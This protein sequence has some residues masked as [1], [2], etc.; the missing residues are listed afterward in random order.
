MK[1]QYL[2]SSLKGDAALQF[3]H[4]PLDD[5]SYAPTWQALLN[6]Y[7]DDKLLKREYFKALVQLEPMNAA[8][9]VELTRIVNETRRLVQGMERLEE[10]TKH[11]NTPL[12][13]LVMYKL[14]KN[15][16]MA[17]EQFSAEQ[18]NDS[19]DK[20]LEFCEKRIRILNSTALHQTNVI[21][22]RAAT[23][24]TY[25]RGRFTSQEQQMAKGRDSIRRYIEAPT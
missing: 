10:P 22:T 9:A 2:L 17:W 1:L 14:E 16:L 7:D 24:S 25:Q 20:L 12:T 21:E 13:I 19:Y 11:W 18:S 8:T 15:T 5:K 4:V 3:E 6:R 23:R